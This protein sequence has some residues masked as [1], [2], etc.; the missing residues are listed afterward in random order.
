MSSI[1]GDELINYRIDRM[2][3]RGSFSLVYQGLDRTTELK[4]AIKEIKLTGCS[5][6]LRGQFESEIFITTSLNHPNIVRTLD[7]IVIN[8][9]FPSVYLIMEYCSGGD[10]SEYLARHG[11]LPEAKCRYYFAQLRD[12]LRYLHSHQIIHRD[13]KPANLLL[14]DEERVLKL[15]DFGLARTLSDTS[16]TETM[17]GSPLYMAPEVLLGEPYRS[18]SDLWSVGMILYQSLTGTTPYQ[19][20]TQTNQII[21]FL[22]YESIRPIRSNRLTT[23]C[24]DFSWGLLQKN[25]TAR[26]SWNQFMCHSWWDAGRPVVGSAPVRLCLSERTSS[27]SPPAVSMVRSQPD[28]M[29]PTSTQSVESMEMV[30]SDPI[31]VHAEIMTREF[32]APSIGGSAPRGSYGPHASDP[33][34]RSNPKPTSR[35]VTQSEYYPSRIES[36]PIS[37]STPRHHPEPESWWQTVRSSLQIFSMFK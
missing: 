16:V 20:M 28:A 14:T 22:K 23:E 8:S 25:P 21:Q 32:S 34:H 27:F 12:G 17:C 24:Q 1:P 2:I 18:V 9:E 6:R 10:F 33:G 36:K 29:T 4:V 15:A 13:L 26:L 31:P 19:G 11:S 37:L 5:E 7:V 35:L 30:S 3:G